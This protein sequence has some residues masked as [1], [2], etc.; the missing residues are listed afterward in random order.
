MMRSL[1]VV[2]I[3]SGDH[4]LRPIW[5]EDFARAI[6]MSVSL[7]ERALNRA[8]R[9]VGP[10]AITQAEL[11]DRLAEL[12]DRRPARVPVPS[13]VAEYGA[14]VAEAFRWSV[15]FESSHLPF[16]HAAAADVDADS[17]DLADVFAIT[18]TTLDE[19][20]PRLIRELGAVA[21]VEGVGSMEVKRF[22]ADIYGS[23]YDARDLLRMFRMHFADVM[24]VSVGVEPVVP[25]NTLT[26]GG[27]VAIKLP[28][29]GHVQVRVHEIAEDRVV[30]ATLRGHA[31]AGIVRFSARALERAVRFEVMTCDAAANALD[32]VGLTLGGARLQDANWSKVV[33]NV[34]RLA[35]G[36]HT[37]VQF[38]KRTLVGDEARSGWQWIESIVQ[39]HPE[40]A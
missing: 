33:L 17:H 22:S 19:G 6:A 1:P 27:V 28:G 37:G 10:D 11:Y 39:R 35:G 18:G 15:P 9:I 5:H 23:R 2:P 36:R 20:L 13:F 32:W 31:L 7:P 12:I 14:R 21:P 38:D 3:L 16:A 24:P 29:R 40:P 34:A 30:V 25:E 4:V 26:D 8:L